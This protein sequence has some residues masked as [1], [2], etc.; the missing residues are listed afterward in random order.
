MIVE[1]NKLGSSMEDRVGSHGNHIKVV[2]DTVEHDKSGKRH[3]K[4][5]QKIA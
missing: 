1:L 2:T 4:L 3:M 5:K